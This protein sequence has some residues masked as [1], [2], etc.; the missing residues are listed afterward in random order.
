MR[1]AVFSDIHGNL[2]ALQ[3]FVQDVKHRHVHRYMCL[4]DIVGYGANPNECIERIGAL[5]KMNCVLGNHDAAAI[6]RYSPYAMTKDAKEVILWTIDQLTKDNNVFLK[7]LRPMLVMGGIC[8]VHANPYNPEAYRYVMNRKY[9]LRSFA[10]ARQRL[11]FIGH[12]HKPVIITKK[13]FF[14]ITFESPG[15]SVAYSL[16]KVKKQ[17][18]NCGSIGQPRDGD[19]RACYC[20][21]DTRENKLEFHRIAYDFQAAAFKIRSAGLPDFSGSRL[22]RG[23]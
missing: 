21:F 6:W 3:A 15:G 14:Q 11:T 8:F 18:I 19:P 20:I 22:A 17:I 10:S 7:Q 16:E 5:P 12:S 23:R 2:E 13:N 1:L 4:G 9:A